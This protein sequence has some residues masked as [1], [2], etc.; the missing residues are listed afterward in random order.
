MAGRLDGKVAIVTGGA[1][2][3]GRATVLRFLAE[4]AS[5]AVG[6]MN[7]DNNNIILADARDAGFDGRIITF[8][9][10]VAEE[11]DVKNL[12]E[13]TVAE[14]D[15]LDIIFN[16]AGV[17]GAVGPLTEISVDDWDYTFHVLVRGVFLGIK[18]ATRQMK[19]QGTGGSIINTASIA[20]ITANSGPSAYSAAKAGVANLTKSAAVE[21]A[22]ERIRV[23]AI[24]PGLILTPLVY[25]GT[26]DRVPDHM[27]AKQ[28]WPEVGRPEDIAA[29]ALFLASDDSQFISGETIVVDGAMTAAG[30]NLW[31][32]NDSNV[33]MNHTGVNR[34]TTGEQ[35]EIRKLED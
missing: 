26:A 2:G 19:A 8:Q 11:T 4:G 30:P 12:I 34:G 23:N 28:P 33:F 13:G 6:D 27:R 9:T 21:L 1:S 15:R 31:G 29:T 3:I 20:A 16:N 32:D 24:A 25:G 5:V 7:N 10:D 18:Y 35:S 17:G 14:F 22:S